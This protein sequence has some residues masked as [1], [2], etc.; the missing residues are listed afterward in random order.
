MAGGLAHALPVLLLVAAFGTF[1][2]VNT[3]RTRVDLVVTEVR[4]PLIVVLLASAGV[5]VLLASLART[6][7]IHRST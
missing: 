5:G 7:W 1:V 4:A 3:R 2:L 6:W